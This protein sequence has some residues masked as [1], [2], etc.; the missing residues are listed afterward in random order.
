LTVVFLTILALVAFAANSI[1]ARLALTETGIDPLSF[2]TIRIVSG[3]TILWM[4]VRF[5]TRTTPADGGWWPALALLAYALAFSLSYMSLT[6]ATGAL[7]L[8]GSVQI[9]M[10]GWAVTRGDRMSMPQWAGLTL[11]AV[12]LVWLLLP[13]LATPPLAGAAMMIAAGIAWGIYTLMAKGADNPIRTTAGNFM[14]ASLPALIVSAIFVNRANIDLPGTYLAIASGAVASGL[15][16]VIW[17][18]ALKHIKT[19][20]AAVSQLTVPVV[21]AILGILLL[22]EPLN[23]RLVLSGV[24]IL[25]GIFLVTGFQSKKID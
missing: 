11:A 1:L 10:V 25:T 21:T 20:T 2:T 14:R 3:A 22:A 5:R 19:S 16:Y 12:G 6:A 13:G 18:A 24:A 9:T 17:Y 8:F 23:P 4:I 7:I 15:G